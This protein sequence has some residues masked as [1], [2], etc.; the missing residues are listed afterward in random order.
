MPSGPRNVA[1][2]NT[3]VGNANWRHGFGHCGYDWA[4]VDSSAGVPGGLRRCDEFECYAAQG[5]WR[6]VDARD[7]FADKGYEILLD[8]M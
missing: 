3:H 5:G 1:A 6:T 4:A 8:G 7:F 2:G